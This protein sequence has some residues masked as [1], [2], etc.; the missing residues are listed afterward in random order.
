MTL[1][2]AANTCINCLKSQIDITEGISKNMQLNHC[3][4]CNRYQRPP[5]VAVE[6]ESSELLS[7]CLK[8]IKGLKRVKLLDASFI[9]TEP[10]SRRIKV[11]LTVQKEVE[12]NT[13]LQQTF[14]VEFVVTNLQC[15]DCKVTYTPHT[16]TAQVQCRQR[17]P[18]KRTFLYLEQLILK[19]NAHEK[20]IGI[21]EC[22]DG[23]DFQYKQ[24]SH[25]NRLIQFVNANFVARDKKT[26]Q[27]ISHN[28]QNGTY[29]YKY[30][31]ILELA[32]ICRDDLVI[33]TPKLKKAL[34]GIGP[35]ILVYK[36]TTSIHIVD[37]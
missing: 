6:L 12:Q 29:H 25:A 26:R 37:I 21:K 14:Q 22:P 7:L 16:W 5:W 31:N 20:T 15:D 17:V 36:V 9:W 13:M 3:R 2:N 35:L 19:H 28:E 23:L 8:Q 34:G 27:L 33:L 24:P 1:P 18:H 11:K 4:E 10:H 30:T 32:P